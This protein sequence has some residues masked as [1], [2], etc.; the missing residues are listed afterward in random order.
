[1]RLVPS[2]HESG[3]LWRHPCLRCR[4]TLLPDDLIGHMRECEQTKPRYRQIEHG[5][6][7][8]EAYSRFGSDL[9]W[10]PVYGETAN[11]KAEWSHSLACK[12]SAGF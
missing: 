11:E 1:M 7:F 3:A 9:E 4:K 10:H 2:L 12:P 5:C 6:N 8:G